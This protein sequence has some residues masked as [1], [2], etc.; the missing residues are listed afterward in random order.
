MTWRPE[1]NRVSIMLLNEKEWSSQ[2]ASPTYKTN[3]QTDYEKGNY[4]AF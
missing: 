1:G 4:M 2:A 3:K